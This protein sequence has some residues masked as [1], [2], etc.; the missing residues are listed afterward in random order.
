MLTP[1][2]ADLLLHRLADDTLYLAHPLIFVPYVEH[3]RQVKI[4]QR[5]G[6]SLSQAALLAAQTLT[7]AQVVKAAA[8]LAPDTVHPVP[9]GEVLERCVRRSTCT[10][11]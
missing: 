5:P 6:E 8:A 2:I 9:L 4:E 1:V 11:D 3:A 10:S 7:H